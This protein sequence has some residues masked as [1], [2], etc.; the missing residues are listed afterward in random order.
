MAVSN[1]TLIPR[2]RRWLDERPFVDVA[3]AA[4]AGTTTVSVSD[5]ADW[6]EGAILEFQDDGE[7]CLVRSVAS[8]NLTVIRGWNGTTAAAHSSITVFRDPQYTYYN[9]LQAIDSAIDKLYP[10]AYKVASTTV[11]PAPTTTVWY[12]LAVSDFIDLIAVEQVYG[13]TNQSLG[14]FGEK[15]S[16]RPVLLRRN[17]PSSLAATDGIALRFPAGFWNNS[18]DVTVKYR[19]FITGTADIE[20]DGRLPVADAVVFGATA[21]L[22]QAKESERVGEG[23]DS[24]TSRSVRTGARAAAGLNMERLWKH[25]LQGLKYNH[26]LR[27][28]P[29]RVAR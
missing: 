20:D 14:V 28:P 10:Y 17:I 27:Y 8:N 2:V 5:G 24:E 11:T 12:N 18:N 29:M 7:Q 6:E 13:S 9:I 4:S 21:F 22:L 26:E 15:D 1:T 16:G 23:E 25:A 19:T 3:T